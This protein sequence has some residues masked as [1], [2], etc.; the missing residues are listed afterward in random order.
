[1]RKR[2]FLLPGFGEDT[3]C[4]NEL[5]PMLKGYELMH[6][7]YRNALNRFVFPLITPKAFAKQLIHQY[8]IDETDR[9]IGHSM[10]GYFSF[11]IREFTGSG[12]CMIASF[13]D[14]AKVRHLTPAFPR[15]SQVAAMTGLV[16]SPYL[17]K[18]MLKRISDERYRSV[19]AYVM[20]HFRQFTNRQL[21][22]MMEMNYMGNIPSALPNPLRI[23][24]PDDRIVAPPDEAYSQT[25]GGHFCLNL[26]PEETREAMRDFLA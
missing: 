18:W 10:G 4:F 25:K 5:I 24:D 26:Y 21:G 12:I 22:L 3:F 16:K 14:T 2:L 8:K 20:D 7:D 23:H 9:L 17:K 15:L 11:Q 13:H 6:V 1:M 19:Q